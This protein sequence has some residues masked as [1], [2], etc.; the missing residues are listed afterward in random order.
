MPLPQSTERRQV[1]TYDRIIKTR[2]W[3]SLLVVHPR[4]ELEVNGLLAFCPR[5]QITLVWDPEFIAPKGHRA[6][7]SET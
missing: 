7:Q 3:S 4:S 5:L 2:A 1:L 6:R